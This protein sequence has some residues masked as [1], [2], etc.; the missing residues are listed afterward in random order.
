MSSIGLRN[1][2]D[3]MESGYACFVEDMLFANTMS[4]LSKLMWPLC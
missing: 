3:E 2:F 1:A 4:L